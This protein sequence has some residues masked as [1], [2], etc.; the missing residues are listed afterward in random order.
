MNV[1]RQFFI[2]PEV[3]RFQGPERAI[4]GVLMVL[5]LV[6][7]SSSRFPMTRTSVAVARYGSAN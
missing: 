4:L 1:W 7:R 6:L 3:F 5:F 2:T